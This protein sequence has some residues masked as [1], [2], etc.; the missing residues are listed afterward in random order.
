MKLRRGGVLVVWHLIGSSLI[1][2]TISASRVPTPSNSTPNSGWC[3]AIS[4]LLRSV[5]SFLSNSRQVEE[6]AVDLNQEKSIIQK[7][8]RIL[9]NKSAVIEAKKDHSIALKQTYRKAKT[10]SDESNG[11]PK[12]SAKVEST[13]GGALDKQDAVFET[14]K[15]LIVHGGL[16]WHIDEN[17]FSS[18]EESLQSE[19][20]QVPKLSTVPPI[21]PLF[22]GNWLQLMQKY[23]HMN[24]YIEPTDVR[25]FY[26][27]IDL[28][29][30]DKRVNPLIRLAMLED[31]SLPA[32]LENMFPGKDLKGVQEAIQAILDIDEAKIEIGSDA[33]RSLFAHF[34]SAR[35][36]E[37]YAPIP[38]KAVL[39]LLKYLSIVLRK[40]SALLNV[41]SIR[42]GV[43]KPVVVY[44]DLHGQVAPIRQVLEGILSGEMIVIFDGDFVD[45]DLQGLEV[46]VI[47]AL[48]KIAHPHT[49]FLVRGNH[50]ELTYNYRNEFI[51]ELRAK[52]HDFSK[53]SL[54]N[55]AILYRS[56]MGTFNYL[57]FAA[58][59][60][61]AVFVVHGGIG[62]GK[63]DG[64]PLSLQQ[65]GESKMGVG[66][67][68][69]LNEM[70]FNLLWSDPIDESASPLFCPS[71]RNIGLHFSKAAT[72]AFLIK[73][74]L[75]C[76]IRGHEFVRDGFK[77][78][79]KHGCMTVF[80]APNYKPNEPSTPGAFVIVQVGHETA[81][82][83]G[84]LFGKPG[85]TMLAPV[86]ISPK[87][88]LSKYTKKK[89][90]LTVVQFTESFAPIR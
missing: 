9:Q 46:V 70:E 38:M 43:K 24:V 62:P 77:F 32:S 80:S 14:S 13:N 18:P 50:E 17:F 89:V 21:D 31:P 3:F 61:Q 8:C 45:R 47:L 7:N 56:I 58:V 78:D 27:E 68:R 20:V 6:P 35:K 5:C 2:P 81:E 49:V 26:P 19:R 90:W 74:A 73:N 55:A 59:V 84:E 52:Y 53:D 69:K 83:Q 30:E 29:S 12:E 72:D 75:T 42:D 51:N 48:L 67:N 64:G 44:G 4:A 40:E 65:I 60:D 54:F 66:L 71:R 36:L 57:P 11:R 76:I 10:F 37:E 25:D 16:K 79:H 22:K 82:K 28:L 87:V 34:T 86:M 41:S 33:I 85:Q 63:E 39:N 15:V 88:K 1:A 23:E